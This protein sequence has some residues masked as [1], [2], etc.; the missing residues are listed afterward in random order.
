LLV[1]TIDKHSYDL[2]T[3]SDEANAQLQSLQFVRNQRGQKIKGKKIKEVRPLSTLNSVPRLA[4]PE[5][6]EGLAMTK[7]RNG[8][9]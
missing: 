5:L 8:K 4:C 2:D 1:I 6:V 3:P 9:V 7:K